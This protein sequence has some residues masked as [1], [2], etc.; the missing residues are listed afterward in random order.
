MQLRIQLSPDGG[1]GFDAYEP[2]LPRDAIFYQQYVSVPSTKQHNQT[3]F[4]KI[5]KNCTLLSAITRTI[6]STMVGLNK[7]PLTSMHNDFV[8]YVLYMYYLN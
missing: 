5:S 2:K 3:K 6:Q 1:G 8:F 7:T 4:L